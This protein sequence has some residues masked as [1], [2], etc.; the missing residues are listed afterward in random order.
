MNR[1]A[2]PVLTELCM[3]QACEPCPVLPSCHCFSKLT[4][5]FDI[6]TV[7]VSFMCTFAVFFFPRRDLQQS[8]FKIDL[9]TVNQ[10]CYFMLFYESYFRIRRKISVDK[11]IPGFHAGRYYMQQNLIKLK[12]RLDR[13]NNPNLTFGR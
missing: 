4:W 2:S 7:G 11:E 12:S 13:P 8:N 10:Q 6:S 1:C 5:P 3:L 9:P